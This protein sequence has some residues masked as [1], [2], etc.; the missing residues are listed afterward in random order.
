[1]KSKIKFGFLADLISILK[2]KI[3]KDAENSIKQL[4]AIKAKTT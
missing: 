3:K 2:T 1:M 4:K